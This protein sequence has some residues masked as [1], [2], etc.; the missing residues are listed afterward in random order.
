[1]NT[2]LRDALPNDRFARKKETIPSAS[3]FSFLFARGYTYRHRFL[4]LKARSASQVKSTLICEARKRPAQ[5]GLRVAARSLFS[6]ASEPRGEPHVALR[7]TAR[8]QVMS[9]PNRIR[10]LLL[11]GDY[12]SSTTGCARLTPALYS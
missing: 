12:L 1:M 3:F 6:A 11:D 5:D 2:A 4:R 8:H 7:R 10:N 9:D